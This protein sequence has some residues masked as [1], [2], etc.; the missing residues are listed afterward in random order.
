MRCPS[1][2]HTKR[3]H[4]KLYDRSA[5]RRQVLPTPLRLGSGAAPSHLADWFGARLLCGLRQ[6]ALVEA[7]VGRP[8]AQLELLGEVQHARQLVLG[9]FRNCTAAARRRSQ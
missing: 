3:L 8:V 4:V 1:S 5:L 6:R 9:A 2:G 7:R